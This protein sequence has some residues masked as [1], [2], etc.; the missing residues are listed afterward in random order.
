[1]PWEDNSEYEFRDIS[2][3]KGMAVYHGWLPLYSI[4]AA[5]RLF[6]IQP[7]VPGATRPQY[8][9]SERRFRTWVGRLPSVVFGM[10]SLIG[11]YLAASSFHSRDAGVIA[12]LIGACLMLHIYFSQQARYYAATI[13]ATSFC[14]WSIAQIL[15]RHR[16]IDFVLGGLFFAFLFHSHLLS[17]AVACGVLG[18][19]LVLSKPLFGDLR[20]PK[21][22]AFSGVIV[23][24]CLPWVLATDF[25]RHSTGIPKAWTL[26]SFPRD[27]F[28][29]R[30]LLSE[31][32]A[33]LAAGAVLLVMAIAGRRWAISRRL[34]PVIHPHRWAYGLLYL[35][36][37]GAYFGFLFLIPAVSYYLRRMSL[38]LTIPTVIVVAMLILTVAEVIN[39]RYRMAIAVATAIVFVL[40]SNYGFP[41]MKE[42]ERLL[43]RAGVDQ[44][45][46][47]LERAEIRPDTRIYATPNEHLVLTFYTGLPVQSIAPI[48]KSFLDSHPG[49]V[50]LFEKEDLSP[51][52]PIEPEALQKLAAG[53][54]HSLDETAATLLAWELGSLSYRRRKAPAVA[55]VLPAPTPPPP[56]ARSA[57]EEH[58][59]EMQEK[60][61]RRNRF[62]Q[63]RIPVFRDVMFVGSVYDWWN[64]FFYRFVDPVSRHRNP[65]FGDRIRNA[66]LTI[67]DGANW[68][69][70]HSPGVAGLSGE[71][72][73]SYGPT[74]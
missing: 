74:G 57:F 17:F 67:L 27:L 42:S 25:L 13:A 44:A 65:N 23:A 26:M 4:A 41:S 45:I 71:T 73:H 59:R 49:D 2:Y 36:L 53:A 5:F 54:N 48:R 46:E 47:Y 64:T 16:W 9:A 12:V 72:S 50:I 38:A 62:V 52:E 18:A 70:F 51:T 11:L 37:V 69:V 24:L 21:L 29:E 34:M 68:A 56:F 20:I 61:E 7:D 33:L 40:I 3:S 1:M 58:E 6:G 10:L 32:G 8:S 14:A 35:W 22:M 31:Y 55:V 39:K 30:F 66:T 60:L 15:R 28:V 63:R 19:G 43:A